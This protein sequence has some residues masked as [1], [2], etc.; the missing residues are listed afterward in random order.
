VFAFKTYYTR[1]TID[2]AIVDI[3]LLLPFHI[4]F[5]KFFIVVKILRVIF[6][7]LEN[8][9][10]IIFTIPIRTFPIPVIIVFQ[11]LITPSRILVT[12]FTAPSVIP[13][14]ELTTFVQSVFTEPEN[15]FTSD[16]MPLIRRP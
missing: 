8:P 5:R 1:L 2:G 3:I 13:L 15:S 16:P 12:F 6:H 9:A 10:R 4:V 14:K 7:A 11:I